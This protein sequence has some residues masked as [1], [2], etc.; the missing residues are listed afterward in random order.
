MSRGLQSAALAVA[1]FMSG[2]ALEK[3][4][5][6]LSPSVAGP[7]PGV[8]ITSPRMVQPS[9]GQR[10]AVDQQ[11]VTLTIGNASTSGVRPLS[12]RFEVAVDAAFT[13]VLVSREGVE[14]GAS[15]QT[16]LRLTDALAPERTYYWH[17]RAQD[18]A[19]VGPYS[20]PAQFA[21]FTPLVLRAPTPISPINDAV[22]SSLRP[23]VVFQNAARTGAS[24]SIAYTIEASDSSAFT[25]SLSA[26][27]DEQPERTSFVTPQDLP[28]GKQ[29]FWRVRAFASDPVTVG[30][31]SDIQV[32]RTP[33]PT[34]TAPTSPGGGGGNAPAADD[35]LD[36][37]TVTILK[38]PSAIVNWPVGSRITNASQGGGELCIW[39]EQL[40]KWPSVI[41]F[42]DPGTLVEGNQWVFA[43]IN[44]KWYGGA[45]DWYRPGQACKGVDASS[46][47]RDSFDQEPLRSWVPRPGEVFGVMSSTPARAW[48]DM[49]T[50]DQRTNII[51]MRWQ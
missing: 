28:A 38:G 6:P 37:R 47:G 44:G 51:M 41:F 20:A 50:L 8:D 49:R 14:P 3:S 48:P 13:N 24:G 26:T 42:G 31:W 43:N 2:C 4:S 5:N 27:V 16:S 1:L 23:T 45:A 33:A 7:I 36:L 21:I 34:P 22:V 18:G 9:N 32:F 11:P 35:Q 12:Y 30:P 17:A 40:G 15:G 10:I 19:N 46:I 39:H 29:V 25:N